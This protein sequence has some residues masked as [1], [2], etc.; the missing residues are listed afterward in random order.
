MINIFKIVLFCSNYLSADAITGYQLTTIT[1]PKTQAQENEVHNWGKIEFN[2]TISGTSAESNHTNSNTN[3]NQHGQTQFQE[4]RHSEYKNEQRKPVMHND[5]GRS[6]FY[7][8]TQ[9]NYDN[10]YSN[11]I[12]EQG[13]NNQNNQ[14]TSNAQSNNDTNVR[15]DWTINGYNATQWGTPPKESKSTEEIKIQKL[16]PIVIKENRD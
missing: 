15:Y 16:T 13:Q 6:D 7:N 12:S 10:R 4:Q 2:Y 3:T 11:N 5:S 8:Q 14:Y 1:L 9:S